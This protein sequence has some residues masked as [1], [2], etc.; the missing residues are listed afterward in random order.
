MSAT[1]VYPGDLQ[2]EEAPVLAER[3]QTPNVER[4]GFLPHVSFDEGDASSSSLSSPSSS[5][6]RKSE[7]GDSS[8]DDEHCLKRFK[9][10]AGPVNHLNLPWLHDD[11]LAFHTGPHTAF[12]NK[13]HILFQLPKQF[14][15]L[16]LRPP[17]FGKS[18]F[19]SAMS[20]FYDIHGAGTFEQYFGTPEAIND[21]PAS[22]HS[23]HLCL[24]FEL[25]SVHADTDAENFV[26]ELKS[27]IFSTLRSFIQKYAR[28]LELSN[29]HTYL[30]YGESEPLKRVLD[31]VKSCGKTLFIGV[32]AYDASLLESM[33]SR[34][35]FPDLYETF[36]APDDVARLFEEHFWRPLQTGCDIISKLFVTG[37]LSL[38]VPVLRDL[39]IPA[40][41]SL[42]SCNGFTKDEAVQFTQSILP[43]Q[44]VDV[45]QL[46][47]RCGDYFFSG[48]D[49][50]SL[51]HP[52]VLID[53]ISQ[54]TSEPSDGRP[55][56]LLSSLL[57]L[58]PAA[59][60][61]SNVISLNG[62][63][64]LVANGGVEID[65]AELESG[66]DFDGTSISWSA[67]YHTGAL[68]RVHGSNSTFRIANSEVLSMIH[69][70]ID[71]L[72]QDRYLV[73][74]FG[75]RRIN[76]LNALVDYDSHDPQ[77][78][79]DVLSQ[80][81]RDHAQFSLRNGRGP[82]PS[83]LGVLELIMRNYR[84]IG[85]R[86]SELLEPI[87]TD[88]TNKSIVRV[89]GFSSLWSSRIYRWEV[90]TL[91][92]RGV[93]LAANPNDTEPSVEALRQ[94]HEELCQED[95]EKMLQRRYSIS[96]TPSLRNSWQS[97]VPAS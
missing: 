41:N 40:P 26:Q 60:E 62:L 91:S 39:V 82:E 48:V 31:L 30:M 45:A 69:S 7:D 25:R 96:P 55:F 46:R 54:S 24:V 68:T 1:I 85:C 16:L 3:A 13:T 76:F 93:W 27:C 28:E 32:D 75:T 44:T 21:S 50:Q 29:P 23:R 61:V 70:R 94:L 2:H 90:T 86:S 9:R 74:F 43:E 97:G 36:V 10:S 72:V 56:H 22:D 81:L 11:F 73:L 57:D 5:S 95:E 66:R 88:P 15:Y 58:L 33:F 12:V 37:T 92:L 63:V 84:L 83:L 52:Q 77:P 18:A 67:L 47:G 71:N 19:V 8:S 35:L 59:S 14:R 87:L 51:L 78:L 6:K 53:H 34:T 4:R 64:E 20:Q 49:E 80:A 79:L 38:E 17:R 65:P 89:Y 42:H